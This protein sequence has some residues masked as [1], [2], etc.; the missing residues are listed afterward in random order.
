M[1]GDWRLP[2][3]VHSLEHGGDGRHVLA[4]VNLLPRPEGP[5]HILPHPFAPV[6]RDLSGP[7]FHRG[8]N[9]QSDGTARR[10]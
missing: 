9:Q 3:Y 7:H 1:Q 2:L 6:E 8:A 5:S 10:L 4:I